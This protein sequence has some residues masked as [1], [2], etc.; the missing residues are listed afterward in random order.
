[1]E[2]VKIGKKNLAVCCNLLKFSYHAPIFF[3]VQYL[4]D[5]IFVDICSCTCTAECVHHIVHLLN[6][7]GSVA[8]LAVFNSCM[9]S[10]LPVHAVSRHFVYS[11]IS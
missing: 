4:L 3:T 10:Y 8:I 5:L 1:M 2:I 6:F 7:H 11:Y 9:C